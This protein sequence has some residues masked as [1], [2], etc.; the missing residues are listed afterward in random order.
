MSD[1]RQLRVVVADDHY[2]LREGLRALLVD[3]GEVEVCATVGSAPELLAAVDEH[4][5]D[6]VI[7]DIRMP[8]ATEGIEAA[9]AIRSRYPGTGVVVLSSTPT[10][11]TPTRCWRRAPMAW[12][13]C[14]RNASA[15][16]PSSCG[17]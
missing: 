5:P 17:P 4:R 11:R 13:T 3:A 8:E 10:A 14:S 7:T 12:P 1:A 9:H 16:S 2:L 15:T 6:A